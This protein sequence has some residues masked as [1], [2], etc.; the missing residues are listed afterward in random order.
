M[1][2]HRQV[3][4]DMRHGERGD[5][6]QKEETHR[7]ALKQPNISMRWMVRAQRFTC[8]SVRG[9]WG[10]ATSDMKQGCSPGDEGRGM[11]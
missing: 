9:R 5:E 11:W 10:V 8:G 6:H 3:I 2:R 4:V 7:Y 1:F